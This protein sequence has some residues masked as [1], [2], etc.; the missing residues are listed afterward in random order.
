MKNLT[1]KILTVILS[2]FMFF[3]VV[4]HTNTVHAISQTNDKVILQVEGLEEG[5]KV[6]FYR[7]AE[8]T[9]AS[10]DSLNTRD[11]WKYAKKTGDVK[12]AIGDDKDLP[13]ATAGTSATEAQIQTL[14]QGIL[15]G[16]I[17]PIFT[18]SDVVA[19]K[20]DEKYVAKLADQPA[21]IYLAII[22]SGS[23]ERSYNPLYLSAT[24]NGDEFAPDGEYVEKSD[25][26]GKYYKITKIGEDDKYILKT[27][28]VP[29][30]WIKV[31]GKTYDLVSS[32]DLGTETN[33]LKYLVTGTAKFS[34]PGV[35]K[36]IDG[37]TV[38]MDISGGDDEYDEDINQ[39]ILGKKT[40]GLGD[41]VGYSVDID[42]PT[43]PFNATNKT[44]WVQDTMEKGL[45]FVP[46]TLELCLNG[47]TNDEVKITPV[48]YDATTH[49]AAATES[50]LT[51]A[52]G[53]YIALNSD[54]KIVAVFTYNT[55]DPG[56]GFKAVFDY[57][58]IVTRK[59]IDVVDPQTG[60][61]TK[62]K[63]GSPTPMDNIVITYGSRV[64][65]DAELGRVGNKNKVEYAYAKNSNKGETIN[66]TSEKPNAQDYNWFE[67]EEIV[68]LYEIS[69]LKYDESCLKKADKF[70]VITEANDGAIVFYK[71]FKDAEH[72][73]L[74][75]FTTSLPAVGEEALY[76]ATDQNYVKYKMSASSGCLLAGAEFKVT[77]PDNFETTVVTNANGIATVTDLKKGEYTFTETKAPKGF[78]LSTTNPQKVTTTAEWTSATKTIT[79]GPS[80]TTVYKVIDD[81]DNE[82]TQVG[83]LIGETGS[84]KFYQLDEFKVA[85]DPQNP[86]TDWVYTEHKLTRTLNGVEQVILNVYKAKADVTTTKATT[87][88]ET[89][90]NNGDAY[91][92]KQD[93]TH[94]KATKGEE[95]KYILIA[96]K[97]TYT[98][99]G[100]TVDETKTYSLDPKGVVF[101]HAVANTTV[102]ELPSTGGIGT[103]L[104]T[105][106]GVA[107]IATAM[108]MLIF[109]K[110]EEHNH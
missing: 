67:D 18:S 32:L 2:S 97:A 60:T 46:E 3:G 11:N 94:Y 57:E 98:A 4:G 55:T 73:Q 9:Y 51:P 49:Q 87:K 82:S 43:Y 61:T 84:G 52:S 89:I 78:T 92:E 1:K 38:T 31:E 103:Y 58:K 74:D 27:D 35:D 13:E 50:P 100:W 24:Y 86:G 83:W 17:T 110:R 106:A 23:G 40:V 22:E 44:I 36:V 99:D 48:L 15:K 90:K 108:F 47:G 96:D 69:I 70:D 45:T 42:V 75:T 41:I 5:D 8:V 66:D 10:E 107:I 85:A 101:L 21:G 56:S 109:R 6:K 34:K 7:L 102:N 76:D 20:E 12:L 54:G 81:N 65:E 77:G 28:T 91:V 53:D 105:I 63:I 93:G 39:A 26:S 68:Y 59:E 88:Q 19:V 29:E 95:V 72:T 64:N 104:F 14:A 79:N 33:P 25:E 62:Q 80:E 71:K 16:E 37:E 30:G